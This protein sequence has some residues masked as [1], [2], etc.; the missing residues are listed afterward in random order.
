MDRITVIDEH[1]TLH[2]V[3]QGQ[4]CII[5]EWDGTRERVV[6]LDREEGGDLI[7]MMYPDFVAHIVNLE[8]FRSI[9]RE[10]LQERFSVN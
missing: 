5:E 2:D 1:G 7:A 10:V 8:Y 9:V 4:W 6:F 3:E